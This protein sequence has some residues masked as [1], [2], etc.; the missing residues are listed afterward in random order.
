M[1]RGQQ[2]PCRK[3]CW[4]NT[5]PVG[6]EGEGVREMIKRGE[7][8]QKL[9]KIDIHCTLEVAIGRILVVSVST[10]TTNAIT[11]INQPESKE[12]PRT[13]VTT[14]LPKEYKVIP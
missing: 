1:F 11:M 9:V 5:Q 8:L 14:C 2:G 7:L 3:D 4:E 13:C 12:L 6:A 10:H